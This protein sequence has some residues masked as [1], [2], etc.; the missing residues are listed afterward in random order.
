MSNQPIFTTGDLG[1]AIKAARKRRRLTQT[2]LA[3]YAN[4]SRGVV[5]KL[6]EGRGT[7]ALANAVRILNTL[8]LDLA[9]QPRG[10]SEAK[11]TRSRG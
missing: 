2:Q 9:V 8:S 1:A 3:D 11:E 10:S 7:V 5:Q 6:E 4:L